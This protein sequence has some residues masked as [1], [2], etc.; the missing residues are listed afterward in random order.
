M[1]ANRLGRGLGAFLGDYAEAPAREGGVSMLPISHIEPN[2]SQPRR[3]FEDEA[4]EELAESI[5][6]HGVLQPLAVRRLQNGSY[7]I[8]AGERRW[9]AARA[10]GLTELPALVLEADDR[11][12]LELS[13]IENLQRQDLNPLEEAEGLRALIEDF[14]LTQ[15]QAAER[16][17][18]SRPALSNSLRLLGLPD[19]IKALVASKKL[20]A[21]HAR[22]LL[23]LGDARAMLQAAQKV[24][25]LSLSVRQTEQLVKTLQKKEPEPLP[26]G[27]E[28]DYLADLSRK[29]TRA[30]GRRV[31]VKQSRGR[32]RLFI[33]YYDI[34][35]LDRLVKAL[36]SI[37][38]GE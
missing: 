16:V 7:Q 24:E 27:H 37:K 28:P 17:G 21:G 23:P 31:Q 29:L 9:R 35:D 12:T 6:L 4:L 25:A 33:D 34:T 18:R 15:E 32:G 1:A 10:A 22:A 30:M 26:R 11:R 38:Q 19:V 36:E 2:A 20:S 8:I 5:K 3:V 13:L 14:G